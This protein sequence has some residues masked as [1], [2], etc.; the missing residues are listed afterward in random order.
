MAGAKALFSHDQVNAIKVAVEAAEQE[1][2][3]EIR[4]HIEETTGG[5]DV[6]DRAAQ[7]FAIL[8][9]QHTRQRN[10]ILFYLAVEDHLFAVIGDKGI[11]AVVPAGFW[12]NIKDYMAA[13]FREGKF[14]EGLAGGIHKAGL[15]LAEHFP[16]HRDD[17]NELSDE[18]SFG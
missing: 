2:S 4:V 9:L 3:G 8:E 15:A 17:I 10:G 5:K 18:I 7:V 16:F 13:H 14:A 11:N 12:D 6:M 1:T